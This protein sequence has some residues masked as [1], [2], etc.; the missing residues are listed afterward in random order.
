MPERGPGTENLAG[1]GTTADNHHQAP[2]R[3]SHSPAVCCL[4]P[5][6]Q[7]C[8]VL[9]QPRS[10]SVILLWYPGP[11]SLSPAAL[12]QPVSPPGSRIWVIPKPQALN[13]EHQLSSSC[14]GAR[15][16]E[17][18][19][20]CKAALNVLGDQEGADSPPHAD[21]LVVQGRVKAAQGKLVEAEEDLRRCLRI[22]C[23]TP[24][25]GHGVRGWCSVARAET[26]VE[27]RAETWVE[28]GS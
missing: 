8:Q 27:W 11:C 9:A 24:C 26:W 14:C 13:P 17:A 18:E 1:A 6:V 22:R 28:W 3:A 12:I 19:R 16:D 7:L 21:I 5:P 10:H 25:A 20:R 4:A 23:P 15:V 2:M